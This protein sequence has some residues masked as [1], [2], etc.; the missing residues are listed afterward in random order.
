MKKSMISILFICLLLGFAGEAVYAFG[1][2]QV[3]PS[4]VTMSYNVLYKD[5]IKALIF[6]GEWDLTHT[7]AAEGRF[8]H[9]SPTNFL[10]LFLKFKLHE[11]SDLEFCGRAGIHSD[12]NKLTD[13]DKTLGIVLTKHHNNFIQLHGGVDYFFTS[14]DLAYFVGL[15]YDLSSRAQLQIGWQKFAGQLDDQGFVFGLRTE[16]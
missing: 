8:I 11:S 3:E 5:Q 10:D 14:G 4:R 9:Q 7:L 16:I 12:F 13:V 6:E 2:G 15:G 1:N